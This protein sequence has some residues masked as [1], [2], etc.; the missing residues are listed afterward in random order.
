MIK[1]GIK[2]QTEV[3]LSGH[4][5]HLCFEFTFIEIAVSRV[6]W[7]LLHKY[8]PSLHFGDLFSPVKSRG[9]RAIGW[10]A[11]CTPRTNSR[12]T[13]KN[14]NWKGGK[15]VTDLTRTEGC[16]VENVPKNRS[17]RRMESVTGLYFS[18]KSSETNSPSCL[19]I[20]LF[21]SKYPAS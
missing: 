5:L 9:R 14:D 15:R 12:A 19:E 18:T 21:V 8:S 13:R 6:T 2:R 16:H 7:Q 1:K 17:G 20:K 4:L 10:S 11:K 3:Y